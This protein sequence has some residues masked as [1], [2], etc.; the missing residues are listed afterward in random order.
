MASSSSSSRRPMVPE[1]ACPLCSYTADDESIIQLHFEAI[2]DNNNPTPP[3]LPPKPDSHR[4]P[5]LTKQKLVPQPQPPVAG[6][7]DDAYDPFKYQIPNNNS[8]E[9]VGAPVW[10]V[11]AANKTDKPA[12]V[13]A[14]Q[15]DAPNAEVEYVICEW[16]GCGEPV[17][18]L[19]LE[20]HFAMHETELE[21]MD[22]DDDDD[23]YKNESDGDLQVR[24]AIVGQ[25]ERKGDALMDAASKKRYIPKKEG[26]SNRHPKKMGQ[27][28]RRLESEAIANEVL[29]MTLDED[30]NDT[31]KVEKL[32][33]TPE[34]KTQIDIESKDYDFINRDEFTE[35]DDEEKLKGDERRQYG[36]RHGKRL[37]KHNPGQPIN[38]YGGY[39]F[40]DPRRSHKKHTNGSSGTSK[41]AEVAARF[42]AKLKKSELGPYANEKRMP[43]WLK[44]ALKEGGRQIVTKN[45]GSDGTIYIK[46]SY[47]NETSGLIPVIRQLCAADPSVKKA[48]VCH[49]SVKHVY[50]EH[51]AANGFCGYR[52]IQMMASFCQKNFVPGCER[53]YGERIPTIIDIQKWIEQAWDRGINAHAREETGGI[54][55]TRKYIGSSEVEAMFTSFGTSTIPRQFSEPN[56]Q[57]NALRHV[58]NYFSRG[59]DHETDRVVQTDKAPIYFQHQ[60]HSMTIVGV[61]QYKCGTLCLLCFDPMF[62]PSQ[63]IRKLIGEKRIRSNIAHGK[64]LKSFRRG[65][66]YLKRYDIFEMVELAP[67][68]EPDSTLYE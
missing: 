30:D 24:D 40:S 23:D 45:I 66:P 25:R 46:K 34:P 9:I 65:G 38:G 35:E 64:L 20:E 67:T 5:P 60:G 33:V 4:W 27:M 55:Y 6:Y 19:E 15:R 28:E 48:Y 58:W 21:I 37:H 2:H 10:R 1:I 42:K 54:L 11:D 17:S 51:P 29:V 8:Q 41:P 13:P 63:N 39:E 26:P 32:I 16:K 47:E 61:E 14:V 7:E 62:S 50:K 18:F 68:F 12:V 3:P 31:I 44:D 22:D 53:L 36:S 59:F 43:D 57:I 49:P 56:Q 52:N